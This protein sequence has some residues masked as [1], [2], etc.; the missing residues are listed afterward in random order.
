MRYDRQL[1][2]HLSMS[3]WH[4][5]LG[6]SASASHSTS[7][8]VQPLDFFADFRI[9]SCFSILHSA[10]GFDKSIHWAWKSFCQ[11]I[12]N[13]ACPIQCCPSTVANVTHTQGSSLMIRTCTMRSSQGQLNIP[14]S[15][16]L[17]T[18]HCA[19]LI[20]VVIRHG[21]S[22]AADHAQ[23][24]HCLGTDVPAVCLWSETK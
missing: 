21:I 18:F 13:A 24:G 4:V 12:G 11:S 6:C 5:L 22:R 20:I 9:T 3:V 8:S 14:R 23:R 16:H 17:I 19:S 15:L 10:S 1:H 2:V 7:F